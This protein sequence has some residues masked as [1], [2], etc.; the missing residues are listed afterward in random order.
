MMGL[1]PLQKEEMRD[2]SL[3][4]YTSQIRPW[5]GITKQ[6]ALTKNPTVLH[7]DIQ[8]V[9]NK[10]LLCEHPRLWYH[11]LTA[12]ADSDK[13]PSAPPPSDDLKDRSFREPI[14]VK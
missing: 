13:A 12:R 10:V 2:L 8:I 14:Q 6:R 11:I 3:S 1:V 7:P 9:R 4:A 5:K